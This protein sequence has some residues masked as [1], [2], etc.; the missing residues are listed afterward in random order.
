MSE[1]VNPKKRAI[2]LIPGL[3]GEKREERY[4][5]RDVLS[6]NLEI[7]EDFP[8]NIGDEFAYCGEKGQQMVSKPLRTGE[9]SQRIDL[10]LFEAYWADMLPENNELGPWGK[11]ANGLE[12]LLYWPFYWRNWLALRHS[13]ILSGSMF[14]SSAI[15]VFWY[16]ALT[17]L[18]TTTLQNDP[19]LIPSELMQ[20]DWF[21]ELWDKFL[22]ITEWIRNWSVWII[23]AFVFSFVPVDHA[24]KLAKW[25]KDYLENTLD[26]NSIGLRDRIRKRVRDTLEC[27]LRERK[28]DE[29]WIV[30]HS[31]GSIIGIDILANWPHS[32]DFKRLRFMTMGSPVAAL[33]YRSRWLEDQLKQL[34][35]N[36]DLTVW[37]DFFS[38]SDWMCSPIPDHKD[39]FKKQ[40]HL[41]KFEAPLPAKLMGRTHMYYYNDP[42][43][44]RTLSSPNAF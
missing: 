29:V 15:L 27:V 8:M 17:L 22:F 32:E 34:L 33:R 10:D 5:R 37:H 39:I 42:N 35:E 9:N 18:V 40:A 23:I 25:V 11:L 14:S 7:L 21:N 41:L 44:L 1:S 24:V 30:A 12:L 19:S 43:V 31:F 26:E 36:K 38:R 4:Y 13:I 16:V 6:R 28:Y 3:P 2:I 20:I